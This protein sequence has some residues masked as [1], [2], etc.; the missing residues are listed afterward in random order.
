MLNSYLNYYR[1][2]HLKLPSVAFFLKRLYERKPFNSIKRKIKGK[3]N[4]IEI[5]H[6]ILSSVTIDIRGNNNSLRINDDCELNNVTFYIR[7]DNH[8]IQIDEGCK[9]NRGGSLWMEDSGCSLRIGNNSSIED[10][11]IAITEP[12]S[13]VVIGKNCLFAYDIEIRTGDSHS[14]IDIG[15]GSRI[16]YAQDVI[17]KDHVWIGAHVSILK[18]VSLQENTVVATGSV[19]VKSFDNKGVILAG[20][21]AVIKKTGITWAFDRMWKCSDENFR[22]KEI[23]TKFS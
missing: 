7:G 2:I 8:T 23:N 14:I 17:I 6:S 12:N 19:V 18:G 5:K 3:N 9:F 15:T 16:N 10:I 11:H 1:K 13:S 20:N 22:V 4:S 21:P